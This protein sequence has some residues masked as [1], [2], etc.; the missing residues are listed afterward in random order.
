MDHIYQS[1]YI[2][3]HFPPSVNLHI[4]LPTAP[5]IKPSINT[6]LSTVEYQNST[7]LQWKLSAVCQAFSKSHL[8]SENTAKLNLKARHESTA[9]VRCQAE[10]EQARQG[11]LQAEAWSWN[12][13]RFRSR[14]L[15]RTYTVGLKVFGHLPYEFCCTKPFSFIWCI[16]C[17]I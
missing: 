16:Y 8:P 11:T 13:Y 4:H 5:F 3:P 14:M 2:I 6:L 17:I 12:V 7:F 9:S 15:L 1:F 10:K